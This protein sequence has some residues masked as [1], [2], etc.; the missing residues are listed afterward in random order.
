MKHYRRLRRLRPDPDLI[1]RRAAGETFRELSS[2][3][4]V[5]HT[6]LSRYFARPEVANQVEWASKLKLE[7]DRA[8]EAR[9]VA[10]RRAQREAPQ[11][12][13]ADWRDAVEQSRDGSGLRD[14]TVMTG[15]ESRPERGGRVLSFRTD[16][17]LW[18]DERDARPRAPLTRADLR[19][20]SDDRAAKAVAD[21][22][23]IQAVIEATGLRTLENVLTGIDPEILD[24]ARENDAGLPPGS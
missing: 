7:E 4:G 23:G 3:Y 6:T 22:G 18:L 15:A 1:R 12:R 16:Y 21:G 10:R 5:S 9:W 19:S 11:Q 8:A 20:K 13:V 17:E 14:R 2:A 24:R